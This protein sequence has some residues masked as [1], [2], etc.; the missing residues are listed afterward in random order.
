MISNNETLSLSVL[1][2]RSSTLAHSFFLSQSRSRLSILFHIFLFGLFSFLMYHK[3]FVWPFYATSMYVL[4]RLLLL[5]LEKGSR[6]TYSHT[7]TQCV[8]HSADCRG[9]QQAPV[10]QGELIYDS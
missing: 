9:T 5:K 2:F 1:L 7:H 10:C 3:T 8:L 6:W 4:L